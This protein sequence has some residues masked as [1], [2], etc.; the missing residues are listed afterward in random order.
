MTCGHRGAVREMLPVLVGD[1]SGLGNLRGSLLITV[2]DGQRCWRPS[3][4][5]T[6][7]VVDAPAATRES[8]GSP[9]IRPGPRGVS[10]GAGA[11]ECF[12]LI[13]SCGFCDGEISW[14]SWGFAVCRCG[15]V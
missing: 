2:K 13:R 11:R 12:R 14:L 9:A 1:W 6:E 5:V 8:S 10:L 7:N 4:H 3:V 15:G